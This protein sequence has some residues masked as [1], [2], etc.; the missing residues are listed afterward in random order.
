MTEK[1]HIHAFL[2]ANSFDVRYSKGN[3]IF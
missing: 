2:R 3:W 1:Y